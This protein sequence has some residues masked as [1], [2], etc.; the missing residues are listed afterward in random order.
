[1]ERN[2][3]W[4]PWE[5]VGIEHLRLTESITGALADGFMFHVF[6]SDPVRLRYQ[7][8]VD[9]SWTVREVDIDLWGP[10]HRRLKL[11]SDGQGGWGDEDGANA[12]RE[13]TGCIDID[14]TATPFTNTLPIRRLDLKPGDAAEIKVVYIRVPELSIEAV[15]QRYTC[16]EQRGT[17][18]RYRYE[19]LAT[20][21][22]A[23]IDVDETGI[24]L[25]YPD[26]FRRILLD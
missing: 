21:F 2:V 20:G 14:L 17:G 15:A 3:V 22:R 10:E 9:T 26:I 11:R 12:L 16:L 13:L 5:G 6:D 8:R 25:D 4:R 18:A 23:E 19:G 24:V 7:I 1:M